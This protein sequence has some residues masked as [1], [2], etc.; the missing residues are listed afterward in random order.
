MLL[1]FY[2]ECEF[3]DTIQI[4]RVAFRARLSGIGLDAFQLTIRL[5]N[6][7]RAHAIRVYYY[8]DTWTWHIWVFVFLLVSRWGAVLL[9]ICTN[10]CNININFFIVFYYNIDEHKLCS[11][12]R[13]LAK[14][15]R[16][17]GE[18]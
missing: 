14:I 18:K 12:E 15:E 7:F 16:K 13:F 5:S 17:W 4:D 6:I 3:N 8:H 10:I 9:F 2:C 11:S 1:A